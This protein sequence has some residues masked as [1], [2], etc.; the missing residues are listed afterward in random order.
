MP[1]APASSMCHG[2][3]LKLSGLI[4]GVF[5]SR[6]LKTDLIP[7][8][9]YLVVRNGLLTFLSPGPLKLWISTA[10]VNLWGSIELEISLV[11]LF[12]HM[13]SLV[14]LFHTYLTMSS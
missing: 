9:Y 2:V 7:Q 12:H 1:S 14:D 5:I 13:I 3:S 6:R 11:D 8:R 4:S 10:V